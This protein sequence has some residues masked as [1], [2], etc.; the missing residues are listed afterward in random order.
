MRDDDK[1]ENGG[2]R[3]VVS[4][5][6][7]S[8]GG[9]KPHPK[10]MA[11]Y[12]K[13]ESVSY[14]SPDTAAQESQFMRQ[15]PKDRGNRRLLLWC[16]YG[17][18]GIMVSCVI[19][20]ALRI[21]AVI[22]KSRVYATKGALD[23]GDV[24]GAWMIWVGSSVAM[25]L[26]ACFLVLLQP[27]GASS[28]IPGLIAFLNG[29][30]PNGGVSPITKKKTSFI[31]LKTMSTKFVGMLCSIPSGLCIGPEGPIIHISALVAYWC[32][33]AVH[34]IEAK[35]LGK[36]FDGENEAEKRDF[37]ATGAACGI[38]TAFRAP[39][40][41]TLFVV[42]EAGSFFTTK[43]LEFTFFSCLVAYWMQWVFG[44]YAGEEG[45]TGAKFNQQTGCVFLLFFFFC[46]FFFVLFLVT[47][48][49]CSF[50]HFHL[51]LLFLSPP[52][53]TQVLLQC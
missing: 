53:H 7:R 13:Y 1:D 48:F 19:S 20:A 11:A 51:L 21:C 12:Q 2:K 24:G 42:E 38:C 23:K 47:S 32:T 52:T 43:H 4:Y 36:D 33:H 16:R 28:G 25:N 30:E 3:K 5:G 45:A 10:H 35:L 44:Y 27:A 49:F 14:I 40:A 22:E 29:V 41:G 8:V 26:F 9:R 31:S 15:T 6:S 39:L 34:L 50:S 37:L 17:V 18:T 46:S